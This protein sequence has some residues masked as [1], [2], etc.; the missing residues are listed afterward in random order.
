M[1][2]IDIIKVES[3]TDFRSMVNS[4][5]IK[6]A[7]WLHRD[8]FKRNLEW[9][10]PQGANFL[11]YFVSAFWHGTYPTYYA[12]FLSGSLIS[13]T[14]KKIWK[15]YATKFICFTTMPLWF[16]MV[17]LGLTHALLQYIT[18]AFVLLDWQV[19]VSY[20]KSLYFYGHLIP[21]F[22]LFFF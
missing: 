15:K 14:E 4:W 3:S 7:Q 18:V 6:V 1:K 20:W 21:L 12:T 16:K 11:T 9:M 8:V 19:T 2:N 5:N 10:G 13:I 22:F 17:R